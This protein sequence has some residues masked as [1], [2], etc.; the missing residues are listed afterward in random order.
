MNGST[1]T[2]KSNWKSDDCWKLTPVRSSRGKRVFIENQSK[3]Q[4]LGVVDGKVQ[5]VEN[6]RGHSWLKGEANKLGYFTLTNPESQKALTA[7]SEGCLAIEGNIQLKVLCRFIISLKRNVIFYLPT[8]QNT[9]GLWGL[10]EPM[11]LTFNHRQG[12]SGEWANVL[13]RFRRGIVTDED[14]ELLKGRVT[15]DPL[16]E[17]DAMYLS[18]TN[19]EAQDHNDKMLDILPSPL[20]QI[21]AI[22]MY[23]KGRE[24]KIKK[25]G[26]IENRPIMNVLKLKIGARCLL[27][28]N[29]NTVDGL[30]NGASGSIVGLETNNDGINAI[31]TKFDNPSCGKQHRGNFPRLADKYHS[32]NGTPIFRQELEIALNSN[33][34]KSLGRGS[35]AKV[36]Q[37]PMMMNYGSTT[38]KIQV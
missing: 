33:K 34:G 36:Q 28:S 16:L 17:F 24:P 25:A 15:E 30:V 29:L 18:F 20:V 10:F 22:K 8:D 11:I 21:K 9:F 32:D 23:P 26:T 31:I 4:V 7:T 19:L 37:F 3:N 1:L 13:N 27:T 6:Q 2:N 38:H 14:Y 5:F 12:A 35:I